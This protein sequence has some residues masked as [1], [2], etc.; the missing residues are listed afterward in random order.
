MYAI[1]SFF[2]KLKLLLNHNFQ[3][4]NVNLLSQ[5]RFRTLLIF[6]H[7]LNNVRKKAYFETQYYWIKSQPSVVWKVN[8]SFLPNK[9]GWSSSKLCVCWRRGVCSAQCISRQDTEQCQTCRGSS[10]CS[11]VQENRECRWVC[12]G[13]LLRTSVDSWGARVMAKCTTTW[14]EV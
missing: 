11:W 4:M 14:P 6:L 2:L 10:I 9:K 5:D 8:V 7:F 13:V 1:Y 12:L 3:G